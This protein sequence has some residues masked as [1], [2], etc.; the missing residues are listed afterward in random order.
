[1]ADFGTH[2]Q[3]LLPQGT[4]RNVLQLLAEDTEVNKKGQPPLFCSCFWQS[5]SAPWP[6][7]TERNIHYTTPPEKSQAFFIVG[8]YNLFSRNL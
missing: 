7:A 3:E 4:V 8:S 1:M 2:N 5:L 6:A